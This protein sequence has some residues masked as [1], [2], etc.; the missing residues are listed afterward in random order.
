[1]VARSHGSVDIRFDSKQRRPSADAP[2]LRRTKVGRR[3]NREGTLYQ[4]GDGWQVAVVS[5]E[6]GSRVYRFGRTRA[7][8]AAKLTTSVK[9][10]ADNVSLAPERQTAADVRLSRLETTVRLPLHL[11][12]RQSGEMHEGRLTACLPR[13]GENRRPTLPSCPDVQ[14]ERAGFSRWEP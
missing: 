13:A 10:V 2:E 14:E 7:E 12:G 3:G 5:H 8:A 4:R 9:A 11:S 6:N 1:M